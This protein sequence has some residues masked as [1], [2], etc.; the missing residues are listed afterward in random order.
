MSKPDNTQP[1]PAS[2]EYGQAELVEAIIELNNMGNDWDAQHIGE[3]VADWHNKQIAKARIHELQGVLSW[4]IDAKTNLKVAST[5][6]VYQRIAE[7]SATLKE[8][9]EK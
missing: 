9:K 8:H 3:L 2:H 5:I 4:N 1:I 7:L 6:T